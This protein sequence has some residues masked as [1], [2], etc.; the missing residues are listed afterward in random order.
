MTV[1]PIEAAADAAVATRGRNGHGRERRPAARSRIEAAAAANAAAAAAANAAGEA[2][3]ELYAN[4]LVA[5]L[6][7]EG[8]GGELSDADLDAILYMVRR[9][10]A[11]APLPQR[12]PNGTGPQDGQRI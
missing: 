12:R 6:D 1:N 7:I 10:E 2:M 4:R 3:G 5:R 9:L 8:I 11:P